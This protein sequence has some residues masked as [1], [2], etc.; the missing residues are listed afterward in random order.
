MPMLHLLH[1]GLVAAGRQLA[2]ILIITA[3]ASWA[4]SQDFI[5][6]RAPAA[7]SDAETLQESVS[8]FLILAYLLIA[9]GLAFTR[10]QAVEVAAARI[11]Q[12]GACGKSVTDL[13]KLFVPFS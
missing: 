13:C 3:L 11:D 8:S 12:D 4:T 5:S 10:G 2:A 7:P 1:A 9:V 6:F